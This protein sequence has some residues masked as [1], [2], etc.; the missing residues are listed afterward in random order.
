MK[1]SLKLL[2]AM[3]VL[4]AAA[5]AGTVLSI[6]AQGALVNQYCAGC[7]NQKLMSGGF[8]WSAV[9]LAHPESSAEGVE[10]V[11]R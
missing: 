5:Q 8:S 11:I 6:A 9:N 4:T 10:K 2:G 1:S 7:H 3:A